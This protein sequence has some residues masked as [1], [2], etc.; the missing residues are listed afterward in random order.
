MKFKQLNSY[1]QNISPFESPKI[2]LEQYFTPPDIASSMVYSA[3]F[4]YDDVMDAS[5]VD[6]GCGTGILGI[7]C[8]LCGA[9]YT[10]G[11]DIDSAVLDTALENV[12]EL[13]DLLSPIDF[14]QLDV[15]SLETDSTLFKGN[16]DVAFMNPPFGTKNKTVDM[17]FLKIASKVFN[18]HT[19]Y[20]LHKSS[21]RSHVLKTGKSL[22]FEKC[23][24]LNEVKFPLPATM[25]GHTQKLVDVD[26]DF[27]RFTKI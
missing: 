22:G 9:D 24:V 11:V 15:S 7:G 6:L 4:S 10:L 5:V 2:F 1:L 17:K 13:D 14:I 26:V 12:L 18:C 8:S 19:V 27:V 21:T 25:K 16:F 3:Y 23:E 20:S